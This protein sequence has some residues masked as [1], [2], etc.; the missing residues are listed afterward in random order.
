MGA[1]VAD[2]GSVVGGVAV[3]GET[4]VG[5]TGV[6]V[7]FSVGQDGRGIEE[8]GVGD[9]AAGVGD[10]PVGTGV[11]E[12]PVGVGDDVAVVVGVGDGLLVP[13]G[14]D[15]VGEVGADGAGV[16][17]VVVGAA[18]AVSVG[19]PVGDPVGACVV[20]VGDGV[21]VSWV[22]GVDPAAGSGSGA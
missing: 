3:E 2:I 16:A 4:A 9:G 19:D 1:A 21:A 8:V 11:G 15:D 12:V 22:P 7:A 14:D 17:V 5:S 13:D 20:A 18:V 6:V 10:V